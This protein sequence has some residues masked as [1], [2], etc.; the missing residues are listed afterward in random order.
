[1]LLDTKF[2]NLQNKYQYLCKNIE[3]ECGSQSARQ[4][5]QESQTLSKNGELSSYKVKSN[6]ANTTE[7]LPYKN[8][9]TEDMYEREFNSDTKIIHEVHEPSYK[10]QENKA[11]NKNNNSLRVSDKPNA[12]SDVSWK[13]KSNDEIIIDQGLSPQL[14][15]AIYEELSEARYKVEEKKI[16]KD[17][18]NSNISRNNSNIHNYSQRMEEKHEEK[19]INT[20]ENNSINRN[21]NNIHNYSQIKPSVN[22]KYNIQIEEHATPNKQ[23]D[24]NPQRNKIKSMYESQ[25]TTNS[26]TSKEFINKFKKVLT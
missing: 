9:Y 6:L 16:N 11:Y 21:N 4:M 20:D 15:K 24:N 7:K 26:S 12:F 22:D 1:M 17:D 13:K 14:N 19:K 2:L 18:N 10:Y 25:S 8:R 5:N 23:Y 3:T